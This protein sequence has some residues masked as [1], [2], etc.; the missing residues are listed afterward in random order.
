MAKIQV[1]ADAESML[2]IVETAIASERKRLKIGLDST[3]KKITEF[4][5]KHGRSSSEFLSKMRA[6]DLNGGDEEYVA[7]AGELKIRQ[8]ILEDIEKLQNVEYV[9][10]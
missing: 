2:D 8:R 1:V 7:W 6:E 3:Q 4:E 10:R 5:R 9:A